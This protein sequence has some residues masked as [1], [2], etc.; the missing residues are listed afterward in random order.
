[1]RALGYVVVQSEQD[2]NNEVE[3]AGTKIVVNTTIESVENINREATVV[4]TPK[5]TV[6]E[7]GDRVLVHH[8]IMRRKNNIK[9]KEIRSQFHIKDG[10]YY[11]PPTE[12]FAYKRGDSGWQALD[13]YCFVAPIKAKDVVKGGIVI[14]AEK[15][16]DNYKGREN[17]MG[18]LRIA[19]R[20]LLEDEGL[21]IGDKVNFLPYSEHEY[22]IDGELLYKMKS[23]DILA[24]IE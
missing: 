24:K 17:G 23:S 21:K 5:G 14:P 1:M 16:K 6:L 13:P 10:Q 2:Y 9:G 12:I 22:K 19:N 15:D 8:N 18:I 3:L 11:V 4:A 20:E 7:V